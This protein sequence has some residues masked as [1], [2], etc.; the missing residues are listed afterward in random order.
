MHTVECAMSVYDIALE[1]RLVTSSNLPTYRSPFLKTWLSFTS[2][3]AKLGSVSPSAGSGSSSGRMAPKK[4]KKDAGS[5][6]IGFR[7]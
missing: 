1:F 4:G 5:A 7:V 2:K 3:L 6:G